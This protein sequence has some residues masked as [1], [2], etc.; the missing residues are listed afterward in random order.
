M[1]IEKYMYNSTLSIQ[2]VNFK[3]FNFYKT[4]YLEFFVILN[5]FQ[6]P[7][8]LEIAKMFI[9]HVFYYYTYKNNTAS[10]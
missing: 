10:S 6:F 8:K 7:F 2:I 5:F 3:L 1:R 9:V 4:E